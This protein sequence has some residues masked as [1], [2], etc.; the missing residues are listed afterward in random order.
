MIREERK[1]QAKEGVERD[2]KDSAVEDSK[3]KNGFLNP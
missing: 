2:R 3:I 1:F